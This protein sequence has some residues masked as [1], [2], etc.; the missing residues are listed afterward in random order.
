M[1]PVGYDVNNVRNNDAHLV[2]PVDPAALAEDAA[3]QPL[4]GTGS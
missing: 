1:H 4:G 3:T 2:D